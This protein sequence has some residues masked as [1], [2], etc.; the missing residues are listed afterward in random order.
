ML[1]FYKNIN[2]INNN[3][4]FNYGNGITLFI[5][6][7]EIGS[8]IIFFF[9]TY[10]FNLCYN[11]SIFKSN[12]NLLSTKKN[13]YNVKNKINDN[14]SEDNYTSINKINFKF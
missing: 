13:N 5:I 3:E 2:F 6:I 14:N 12:I 4:K 8:V 11:F 1:V 10:K 9:F 7:L